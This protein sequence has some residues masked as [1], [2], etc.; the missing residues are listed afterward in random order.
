MLK[1]AA[2]ILLLTSCSASWHLKRAIKKDPSLLRPSDTVLVSDT[3]ITTKERVIIDSF[4]TT[5]YDTL[6]IEDSF[7]YTQ[8]IRRHDSIHVY[9]RCKPDTI[10]IVTRIPY[11]APERVMTEDIPLIKK[12]SFIVLGGLLLLLLLFFIKFVLR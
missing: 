4:V 5:A 1:Y 10:R 11:K 12:V 7:V 3:L 2:V 8:V 9:T 6:I